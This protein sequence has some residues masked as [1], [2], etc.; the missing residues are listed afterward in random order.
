MTSVQNPSIAAP[1]TAGSFPLVVDLDGTLIRTDMLHESRVQI[2]RNTP[3]N[4]CRFP[5]DCTRA[6]PR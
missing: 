4:V 5:C 2:F 3:L 1:D 6:R